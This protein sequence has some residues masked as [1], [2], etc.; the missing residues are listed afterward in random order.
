MSVKLDKMGLEY[1]ILYRLALRGYNGKVEVYP[2]SNTIRL[3][4]DGGGASLPLV[5]SSEMIGKFSSD[6]NPQFIEGR[7]F[8]DLSNV[9]TY[10]EKKGLLG[11]SNKD[12]I[13]KL[14]EKDSEWKEYFEQRA[15]P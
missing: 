4:Y 11:K 7:F 6:R 2:E 8:V 15:T 12:L 5:L 1:H 13:D 9:F 3:I 14:L 10:L